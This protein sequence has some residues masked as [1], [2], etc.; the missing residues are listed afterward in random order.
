MD[1]E[2]WRGVSFSGGVFGVFPLSVQARN[3]LG[4]RIC[5]VI[6]FLGWGEPCESV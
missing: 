3:K 5:V 6:F 1:M 2:G 4:K